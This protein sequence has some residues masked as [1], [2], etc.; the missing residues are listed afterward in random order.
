[1]AHEP[2]RLECD[3]VI[4]RVVK[5]VGANALLA[6]RDQEDSLKPEPHRDIADLENS[7]HLDGERLTGMRSTYEGPR[8]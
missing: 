3:S 5:L 8:G 6:G 1:M 4:P 2:R 7:F